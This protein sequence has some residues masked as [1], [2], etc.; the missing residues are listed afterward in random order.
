[1]PSF[2]DDSDLLTLATSMPTL[3]VNGA[4]AEN[5]SLKNIVSTPQRRS[6]I[7]DNQSGKPMRF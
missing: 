7:A 6:A 4:I 1:M 5:N 2:T 3:Q